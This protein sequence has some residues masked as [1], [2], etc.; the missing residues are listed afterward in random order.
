MPNV[1]TTPEIFTVEIESHTRCYSTNT[2]N[3]SL[4]W[5]EILLSQQAVGALGL[6]SATRGDKSAGSTQQGRRQTPATTSFYSPRVEVAS[7]HSSWLPT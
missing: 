7:K 3:I 1:Q 2:E 5:G 4:L 6:S